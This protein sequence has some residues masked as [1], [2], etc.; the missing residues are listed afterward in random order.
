M[1]KNSLLKAILVLFIIVLGACAP[2]LRTEFVQKLPPLSPNEEVVLIGMDYAAVIPDSS[3]VGSLKITDSGLSV[4]CSYQENI[5]RLKQMSREAGANLILIT[6]H[7]HANNWSTCDRIWANIYAVQSP[8]DYE[9]EID[10]TESRRLSWND[11]KGVVPE[12]KSQEF[13]AETASEL[14]FQFRSGAFSSALTLDLQCRFITEK[15]WVRSDAAN[16]YVLGHEQLHFDITELYARMLRKRLQDAQ[17]TSKDQSKAAQMFN[18]ISE[19][20]RLRQE[21]YDRQTKHGLLKDQQ[22][23]WK[24]MILL[25][26]AGLEYWKSKPL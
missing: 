12:L 5:A 14:E 26:L 3:Q 1:S 2:K 22:K 8:R 7:L 25:E 24:A 10:W 15:S 18:T 17:L 20:H 9:K 19:E 11:F 21:R 23:Q 6:N 16:D 13:V 4:N